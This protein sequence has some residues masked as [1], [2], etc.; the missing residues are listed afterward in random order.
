MAVAVTDPL[1]LLVPT[2]PTDGTH[3]ETPEVSA[4]VS[5]AQASDRD[6]YSE[7]VVLYEGR[8]YRVALAA[9]GIREDAED[10]AQDGFVLA[11]QKLATFRGHSTFRTWL[12]VLV[13][14]CALDRRRR[15]RG[16]FSQTSTMASPFELA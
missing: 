16:W 6:A 12:L 15:R 9:L 3:G 2:R 8:A 5:R 7:L 14:R 4:L 11:W 13:W 1:G 10:A